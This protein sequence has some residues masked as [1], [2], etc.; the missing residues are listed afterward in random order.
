MLSEMIRVT[1]LFRVHDLLKPIETGD[2]IEDLPD[3]D[4]PE[5]Q[6]M[7]SELLSGGPEPHFYSRFTQLSKM[8]QIAKK[9]HD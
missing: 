3:E 6:I 9:S 1:L 7:Q 5:A 4:S 2:G 8:L